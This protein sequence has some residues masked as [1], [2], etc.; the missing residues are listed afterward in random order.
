MPP[1]PWRHSAPPPA[2]PVLIVTGVVAF[3]L[4]LPGVWTVADAPA[5][6][7]LR[8][9]VLLT[10]HA[11]LV[12][13]LALIVVGAA[14]RRPVPQGEERPARTGRRA[15]GRPRPPASALRRAAASGPALVPAA[16]LVNRGRAGRGGRFRRRSAPATA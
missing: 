15:T 9:R 8:D 10:P 16:P 12:A 5:P 14:G 6:E 13:G 2:A 7:E 11:A 3:V 1:R 4:R